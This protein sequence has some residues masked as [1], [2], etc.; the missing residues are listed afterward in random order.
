M[1]KINV[2]HPEIENKAK[3]HRRK[4]LTFEI[5]LCIVLTQI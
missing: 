4:D 2:F 5:R 3:F 1:E